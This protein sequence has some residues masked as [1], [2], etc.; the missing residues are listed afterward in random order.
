M[1]SRSSSSRFIG[2]DIGGTG[3]RDGLGQGEVLGLQR[4][5]PGEQHGALDRVI[6]LAH[7]AGPVVAAEELGASAENPARCFPY[8]PRGDG[9]N[10]AQRED[11]LAALPKR[12]EMDLDGVET[13][14]QV[15]AE[16]A[17]R[18]PRPSGRHWWRR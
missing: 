8:G 9:G 6:E 1:V 14:E 15:L 11:V 7:V 12:R 10:T 2:D 3:A 13:E 18:P 5:E 16:A 17:R 4:V